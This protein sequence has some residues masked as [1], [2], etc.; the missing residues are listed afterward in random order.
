MAT[1]SIAEVDKMI[2][3]GEEHGYLARYD[4]SPIE[5]VHQN[6]STWPR[7][8]YAPAAIPANHPVIPAWQAEGQES[9]GL[10]QAVIKVLDDNEVK[11]T[12][13]CPFGVR[14]EA[15]AATSPPTDLSVALVVMVLPDTISHTKAKD[16]VRCLCQ[17]LERFNL[18][19]V[20]IE[21]FEG[22]VGPL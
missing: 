5:P 8:R 2:S 13:A 11:F 17:V 18:L 14:R 22:E 21:M 10:R 15:A 1:H 3:S 20:A 16:V 19:D 7:G 12:M 6:I 4:P 9:G